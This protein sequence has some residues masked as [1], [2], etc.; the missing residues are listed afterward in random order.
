V[1]SLRIARWLGSSIPLWVS[2]CGDHVE[3]GNYLIWHADHESGDTAEWQAGATD[4]GS[5]MLNASVSDEQAHGGDY[6]LRLT[7]TGDEFSVGAGFDFNTTREAYFSAWFYL[8]SAYDG[9]EPWSL[10]GFAS[11]GESC[12]GPEETCAGVEILL[13]PLTSGEVLLYVFNNEPD[14][15]QPPLSDPPY[16][17]PIARWFHLEAR[18]RRATD[19]TGLFYL[20]IDGAPLFRFDGWRTAEF[21]NLFWGVGN[22]VGS[23]A[24]AYVDDAAISLLAV[25]PSGTLE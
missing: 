19:H 17:V 16:Y 11:R 12:T 23:T 25:T 5:A 22:P 9:S 15:V 8:P 18:Y 20:W 7:S 24:V 13:R 3:L 1:H 4:A 10:V 14:V 21:D 6:S 2:A